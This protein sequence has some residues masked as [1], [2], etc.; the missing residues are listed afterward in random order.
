VGSA[1]VDVSVLTTGH[2]VADARLH[3][4]VRA[5]HER[6]LSVDVRGLGEPSD[7]PEGAGVI[8]RR[9]GGLLRRG[10]GAV[11]LPWQSRASVLL[12]L[13]PDV[14]PSAR[15]SGIVRRRKVVVD[16]HEDYAKLLAD[17]PWS[18]GLK[19]Y[20]ARALVRFATRLAARADL[21]VVADDHL[22]PKTARHRLVVPNFPAAAFVPAAAAGR[23]P[24]PR[25]VYVGDVRESRG[26]FDMVEAIGAAPE[27]QLDIVGPVAVRDR[28]RLRDRLA[29]PDVSGRIRVHDR[30]PPRESW[31]VARGAWA[32]LCLLHDTPAFREALP[33]K[34]HE[35]L[36]SGLALLV[37]DLPRQA[38][39]VR[40]SAAGAVVGSVD[41]AAEVL[42]AWAADPALVDTL[43][44]AAARARARASS[45]ARDPYA[46][47]A[48]VMA[49]L[50]G[51]P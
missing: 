20:A 19:A 23:D 25:A 6:G 28:S 51:L 1:A 36:A 24:L 2:D 35:Y 37:S 41:E 18:K 10:L 4:I 29:A 13:D 50:A 44:A 40:E 14:I 33:T 49:G 9:R 7:G 8:A 46:T 12:T 32:G 3:K 39:V 34:L 42:R 30:Q 47:L 45:D 15:L 17:R 5:L 43:Q 27:W 31:L 22:P 11:G 26:L 16:V 38:R 48:D 21:T